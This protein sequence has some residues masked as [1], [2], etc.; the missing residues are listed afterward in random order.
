MKNGKMPD[1][2]MVHPIPGYEK[3]IY[4]K[5]T[6]TKVLIPV[7]KTF[8]LRRNRMSISIGSE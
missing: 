5:P 1:P 2:N 7:I 3:E 6:V 4:V 8:T